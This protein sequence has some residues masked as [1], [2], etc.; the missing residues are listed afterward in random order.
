MGWR[1]WFPSTV[2]SF[3]SPQVH[4]VSEGLRAVQSLPVRQVLALA[5]TRTSQHRVLGKLNLRPVV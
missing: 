1:G 5:G 2:A 3:F 4:L